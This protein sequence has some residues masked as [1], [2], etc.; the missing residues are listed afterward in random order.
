MKTVRLATGIC[1]L[2]LATSW[3][4]PLM[5]Q[6]SSTGAMTVNVIDASGGIL[7]GAMVTVTNAS[8]GAARNDVTGAQG[9]VTFSLLPVGTYTVS[10]ALEGFGTAQV[11]SVVIN[12]TETRVLTQA[13]QVGAMS[14]QLTV[15]SEAPAVQTGSSALGTVVNSDTITS[16]PLVTRNYT[17]ILG[18]S[19]GTI[20][21]VV[22]AGNIGHGSPE[23]Y[24]NGML[25]NGNSYQMDG[26]DINSLSS[27]LTQ[28]LNFGTIAIPNPDTLQE[29]KVQT[30]PYDAGFGRNAGGNVNVV[31]KSGTNLLRGSGFEFFRDDAM[32]A[33]DFF[34]NRNGLERP[35]LKQNQYGF[36]FGGP[37]LRNKLFF[38]TSYQKT[39]QKNGLDPTATSAVTLP[40]QLT[41]NRSAA[42]LGG[43]FCPENSPGS[44]TRFGGVQVACDGSNINP[45]AL[46][47]LNYR[48]ADGTYLIPTPQTIVNAGTA[49]A[50]GSSIFSVPATYDEDQ[51]LANLDYVINSKHT[52]AGRYFY[53]FSPQLV[54]FKCNPCVPGSG[55]SSGIH[56]TG[57][58][59]LLGRVTSVLKS[60]LVNEAR[61]SNVYLRATNWSLDPMTA[62]E[63]GITPAVA[64]FPLMPTI[65]ISGLFGFGGAGN[66]G[67]SQAS[68]TLQWSD[69][70][71]WVAGRHNVRLGYQGERYYWDARVWALA[72]GSLSFQTFPDFLLGMSAAQNGSQF[73]NV[74]NSSALI[75]SPSLNLK[76]NSHVAFVQ[77]DFQI[78]PRLTVNLGL[79]WEY[80]GLVYDS[81]K[82]NTHNADWSRFLAVPIPPPEGTYEG[83][84]MGQNYPGDLP[85][86][87]FR[88]PGNTQL[89]N[90]NSPYDDVAPRAGFA[91]QPLGHDR[92][93]VR[94]GW[95][96]LMRPATSAAGAADAEVE[97]QPGRR[98]LPLPIPPGARCT[99]SYGGEDA[100]PLRAGV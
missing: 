57:N 2:V 74:N 71:S 68:R 19:P 88:R 97:H 40:A 66:N 82:G 6:T 14:E 13:L 17:Q 98:R 10:I 73:S 48:T 24:V 89:R 94:G 42:A 85:P 5:A 39:A 44:V 1:L 41:D 70:L 83:L 3:A 99:A 49:N 46:R 56:N 38:F 77:D 92:F 4:P 26:A 47:L 27:G 63:F 23:T 91:W 54:P 34:R 78:S 90:G 58:N 87:V 62:P 22:N 95:S 53:A 35:V 37:F 76:A 31:T 43:A 12:V 7:P 50:R 16:L 30:S 65:T 25:G 21:N 18:L 81:P 45:V 93:V 32:N 64:T 86:G 28:D 100:P 84:T 96:L 8:T 72:R 20:S 61:V 67:E 33:N 51:V 36:T 11:P 9:N 55:E 29:F 75:G 69:Q 52:I 15:T 79:R 80:M 60:N 59:N